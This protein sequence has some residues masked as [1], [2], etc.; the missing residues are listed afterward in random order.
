MM[1][2]GSVWLR[3]LIVGAAFCGVAVFFIIV[4]FGGRSLAE[5]NP[6]LAWCYWP[7]MILIWLCALPCFASLIPGWQLFG[8]IGHNSAFCRENAACLRI[9]SRL[10]FGDSALFLLG[11]LLY[12]LLG[13][14]HPALLLLSLLLCFAGAAV[15]ITAAVL[16][17]LVLEAALLREDS[18]L[19]I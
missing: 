4:P 15:G 5:E 1:K 7:W 11:N 19:T 18:E 14:N 8:R 16:S 3:S 13:M 12:F 2:H 9:I 17:H 10:A 6:E